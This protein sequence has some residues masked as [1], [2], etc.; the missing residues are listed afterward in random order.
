MGYISQDTIDKVLE[1][2]RVEE[3]IGEFVSLKRAGSNLKGFSPFNEERTPSFMVSPA[4]Q[5]WKDFSSGKGGNVVK[6]LMEYEKMTFP[7]AIRWLADRYHIEIEES[8]PTEEELKAREEKQSLYIV[9]EFARDWYMAQLFDTDEGRSAGLSYFKQ[10]G[11]LEKTLRTFQTGYAPRT[12]D[13]FYRAAV[14]RGFKDELLEKAGLIIRRNNRVTDRFFERVMFPIHSVSGMVLGFAGRIL[15]NDPKAAKYINTPETE[16]YHKSKILYGIF[17]AKRS[18]IKEDRV[19]LVEGYTDVMAFHQ[20]GIENTVA[21]A[22]TA[23][24]ADQVRLLKQFT[25]NVVLIYDGDPAGIKAAMRGTDIILENDMNVE[26]VML[27]EGEDPDSFSRKVSSEELIHYLE[28]HKKNFIEFKAEWLLKDNRDPLRT[29]ELIREVLESIAGIPDRIKQELYVR[30]IAAL[31]GT[32]ESTLF[33]ELQKILH[34]RYRRQTRQLREAVPRPKME[35]EDSPP[36]LVDKRRLYERDIVKLLLLYGNTRVKFKEYYIKDV[37]GTTVLQTV[38]EAERTVAEK[39]FL[40]LQADEIE[41]STPE[42]KFLY[43]KIMEQY[44]SRGEI[45][46]VQLLKEVPPEYTEIISTLLAEPEQH[47]ITPSEKFNIEPPDWSAN[48]D[49]WVTDVLYRLR[50][51]LVKRLIAR[52]S[53]ELRKNATET[54]TPELEEE[55]RQIQLWNNM[56]KLF[57]EIVTQVIL[58]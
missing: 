5:I 50:L 12:R 53:E 58:P 24:T 52:K 56:K 27:P 57:G 8:K 20:A 28:T 34:N 39:I 16:V 23:L 45:D 36:K 55:I 32:R 41:F 4:K 26:V 54:L 47:H 21:S 35:V 25:R 11:F 17:Q 13:A 19:F 42:F 46:A 49:M 9:L 43:D 10:R 14:K 15:R 1:V 40:E 51:E 44:T 30:Q 3:V 48:L 33:M 29:Y 7:E 38:R 37:V 31:T 2:A 18:I 6:F 22:G